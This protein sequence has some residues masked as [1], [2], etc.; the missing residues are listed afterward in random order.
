[1]NLVFLDTETTGL[2][3]DRHEVWEIAWAVNDGPIRSTQLPHS[4][5]HADPT[6]LSMNGYTKRGGVTLLE[7]SIKL[8]SEVKEAL[9]G[10]ILVAANPAFDASFLRARWGAAPWHYRLWDLE[11]FAAGVL[12]M[13]E[14]KGLAFI[15]EALGHYGFDI[16][17]PDHSAAAD[18]ATLRASFR[19]LQDIN[20][21]KATS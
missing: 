4:L 10:S 6:A 8:E 5:R 18:V 13:S 21:R 17:K 16:P 11:A 12:S 15:A 20:N 14:P 3:P 2:D 1:M 19:A 9:T 7:A